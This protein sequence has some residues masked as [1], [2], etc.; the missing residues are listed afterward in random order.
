MRQLIIQAAKL[1]WLVLL[2]LVGVSLMAANQLY[3]LTFNVSTGD[4]LVLD[5]VDLD[6]YRQTL[7]NFGSDSVIIAYF[8]DG[9]LATAGKLQAVRQVLDRI[10]A[11]PDVQRSE[12]LFNLP[13]IRSVNGDVTTT[14]YLAEV[15]VDQERVTQLFSQAL[16][17]PFV[18]GNLLAPSHKAMAAVFYLQTGL[19][20]ARA[21][22]V[23]NSID[24]QLA[25]LQQEL[26]H[27]FQL[28]T[29]FLN[30]EIA[31]RID[32]DL[33]HT[34]PI[35]LA[36]LL[37]TL[38]LALRRVS[39]MLIPLLSAGISVLWTL[40]L[41]AALEIPL[42]VVTVI[43]PALLITIGSTEDIHLLSEYYT[44]RDAGHRK[45]AAVDYMASNM[46]TIIT[47][48][49]F[50]TYLGFLSIALNDIKLLSQFGLIASSGLLINYLV[51]IS[52]VPV[53]LELFGT[54]SSNNAKRGHRRLLPLLAERT[55]QI[56]SH[57]RPTVVVLII[58]AVA[59]SAA[60]IGMLKPDNTTLGYF[61]E[62]SELRQRLQ[63]IQS[64]LA[65][66]ETMSIVL[67][68]GIEG[69]FLQI[70]YLEEIERLQRYLVESG[71]ADSTLSFVDYLAFMH[72]AM[73]EDNSAELYLPDDDA[74]VREYM[75][76]IKHN[77][78]KSYLSEDHSM[79]RIAIRHRVTSSYE[80]NQW[81]EK[82]RAHI[83][84]DVDPGLNVKLT[85]ESLL[86]AKAADY[87]ID[88][89]LQ[90]LLLMIA[91]IFMITSVLFFSSKAGLIAVLPNLLPI[92]ILF[93]TMGL[94]GLPLNTGTAMTAS[95][96][97]GIC[98]DDTMHFMMRYNQLA[99][100]MTDKADVLRQ[101][102]RHEA[103]P[104]LTT[105][106]ALALGFAVMAISNFPPIVHFGL[107]SAFVIFLAVVATFIFT[108]LLLS[109]VSLITLWDVLSLKLKRE[110]VEESQLFSGLSAL[111]VRKA[112]LLGTMSEHQAGEVVVRQGD[113]GRN[114][115]IML[116]GDAV[117]SK[118]HE[119]G[120][121]NVLD[122]IQVGDMFGEIALVADQP[123]MAD[124]TTQSQV[125][126]LS[127]DRAALARIAHIYPRIAA[128]ILGNIS[129][130]LGARFTRITKLDPMLLDDETGALKRSVFTLL[131]EKEISAARRH[132]HPLSLLIL[133]LQGME[134]DGKVTSI[135]Q[136]FHISRIT[137]MHL[138]SEDHL[139]RWNN[140]TFILLMPKTGQEQA[141]RVRDRLLAAIGTERGSLNHCT[142]LDET[143]SFEKFL[144]RIEQKE[145]SMR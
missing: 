110:V 45:S 43:V 134:E 76:F 19:D 86:A 74:M 126:L 137:L 123:R 16:K 131:L 3:K 13:H 42:N 31:L 26:E 104:I 71:F 140:S 138:R 34:L 46:G 94:I 1:P 79:A 105:S 27:A 115:Y 88:A 97:L 52:L 57:N 136:I 144:K 30:K 58:V 5:D 69:T 68:S 122:T 25:T 61:E 10:E 35:A 116:D 130:V 65:G 98:V 2:I 17:N 53:L 70:H 66:M 20:E 7:Q 112:V 121:K 21:E 109:F 133:K 96:A 18:T 64:E 82:I 113:M 29:P 49:F 81:T 63:T 107:L 33:R 93:G 127:F 117:V 95:I 91:V 78:V 108:P 128:K 106:V 50:T 75:L 39:G 67:D 4:M 119:D 141:E 12:S 22:V 135:A 120:S 59:L 14:P 11:L 77:Q 85:G 15:P 103:I 99:K 37:I 139:C 28:G 90:S 72:V 56:V 83:A 129:L 9:Q 8:G 89:Q 84:A 51:T 54:K 111:Q 100:R 114:L 41:M 6:Y 124:V 125:T 142:M 47:L 32:Q 118:Q 36:V 24:A 60:G 23:S 38:A 143:E 92:L 44:L 145:R 48:T 55:Y 80:L 73:E 87:M 40:G 62:D 132:S 102:V 101:T